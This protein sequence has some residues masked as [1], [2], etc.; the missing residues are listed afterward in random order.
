MKSRLKL[1]IA[2]TVNNL[3][4]LDSNTECIISNVSTD[5][6]NECLNIIGD[7][8]KKSENEQAKKVMGNIYTKINQELGPKQ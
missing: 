1:I 5:V 2:K 3:P 6:V 4:N 8:I 7:M